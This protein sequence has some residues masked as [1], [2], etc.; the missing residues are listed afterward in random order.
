MVRSCNRNRQMVLV[1]RQGNRWLFIGNWTGRWLGPEL[2]ARRSN[3]SSDPEL[4]TVVPVVRAM[5]GFYLVW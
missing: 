5:A 3:D 1:I 2:Q 4:L